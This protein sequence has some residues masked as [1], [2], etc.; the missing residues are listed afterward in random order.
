M[1]TKLWCDKCNKEIKPDD[2]GVAGIT[3]LQAKL[4]G[5]GMVYKPAQKDLCGKCFEEVKKILE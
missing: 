4:Q 3:Y 2:N 1:T 5:K